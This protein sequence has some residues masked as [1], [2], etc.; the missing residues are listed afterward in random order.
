MVLL[1]DD[2]GDLL[3]VGSLLDDLRSPAGDVLIGVAG[4]EDRRLVERDPSDVVHQ[5]REL[6]VGGIAGWHAELPSDGH[7]DLGGAYGVAGRRQPGGLRDASEGANGLGVGDPGAVVPDEGEMAEAVRHHGHR[8]GPP[9]HD[10]PRD[11]EETPGRYQTD[12]DRP[13]LERLQ[14]GV[15]ERQVL[16]A[17]SDDRLGERHDDEPCRTGCDDPH[18]V[19]RLGAQVA[20]RLQAPD[21]HEEGDPVGSQRQ[22]SGEERGRSPVPLAHQGHPCPQQA[23]EVDRPGARHVV[24]QQG[25]RGR[26]AQADIEHVARGRRDPHHLGH[27]QDDGPDHQAE[28]GNVGHRHQPGPA[29]RH[30]GPCQQRRPGEGRLSHGCGRCSRRRRPGAGLAHRRRCR[31]IRTPH[32]TVPAPR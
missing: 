19:D 2:R 9:P 21:H 14:P 16:I 29:D 28:P 15:A 30:G 11:R 8:D 22:R 17:V 31:A 4:L 20:R 25:D 13:V 5:G 23:E 3:E 6:E 27:G 7:R 32:P 24:Q 1:A 26:H 10:G 12:D 18:Q